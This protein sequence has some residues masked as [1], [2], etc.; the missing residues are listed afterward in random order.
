MHS[1]LEEEEEDRQR[2][3]VRRREAHLVTLLCNKIPLDSLKHKEE[4]K[5]RK[6][7]FGSNRDRDVLPVKNSFWDPKFC[8]N[9]KKDVKELPV[10]TCP[11]FLETAAV[12]QV[13]APNFYKLPENRTKAWDFKK[14]LPR[15]GNV[16]SNS[17][18][19]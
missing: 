19:G 8:V 13:P 2:R 3:R 18:P 14:D 4:T 16:G 11:R 9:I 1:I 7:S 17:N 6:L 10:S 15:R 5:G 12:N